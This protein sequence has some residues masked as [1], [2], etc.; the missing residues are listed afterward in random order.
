MITSTPI[1][2][3][4]VVS[5]FRKNKI[6][7]KG[8]HGVCLKIPTAPGNTS[9]IPQCIPLNNPRETLTDILVESDSDACYISFVEN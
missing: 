8:A 7:W 2:T 6:M 1:P 4:P 3:I 5:T 9:K